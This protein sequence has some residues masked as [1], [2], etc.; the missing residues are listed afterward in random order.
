VMG[1][2]LFIFINGRVC[3]ESGCPRKAGKIGDSRVASLKLRQLV[4]TRALPDLL[5]L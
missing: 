1:R 5:D 3:L 2:R 4:Y